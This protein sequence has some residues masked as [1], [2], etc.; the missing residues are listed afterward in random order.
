MVVVVIVDPCLKMTMLH[1]CYIALF[2]EECW[3]RAK[4]LRDT[5]QSSHTHARF[6]MYEFLFCR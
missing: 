3:G 2:G 5:A 6:D 4:G 1:A